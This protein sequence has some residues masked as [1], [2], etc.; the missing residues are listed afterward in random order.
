MEPQKQGL[1]F[2]AAG[3][4]ALLLG[5]GLFVS[6][7]EGVERNCFAYIFCD[8]YEGAGTGAGHAFGLIFL[9]VGGISLVWGLLVSFLAP[10]ILGEPAD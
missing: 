4:A 5:A 10:R 6:A 7:G 8:T 9:A 1:V 2:V 3:V